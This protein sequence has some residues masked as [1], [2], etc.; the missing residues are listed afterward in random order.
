[1]TLASILP[2][3]AALYSLTHPNANNYFRNF[4]CLSFGIW[5]VVEAGVGAGVGISSNCGS[6]RQKPLIR[7]PSLTSSLWAIMSPAKLATEVRVTLPAAV[8]LPWWLPS[9]KR[10]LT[11]RQARSIPDGAIAT[12]PQVSI[13]V[14]ERREVT[15]KSSTLR[16]RLQAGQPVLTALILTINSLPQWRQ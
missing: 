15:V 7:A 6:I 12:E 11:R 16:R 8:T 5:A 9:T 4:R 13:R 10:L 2:I 3:K 1:L 14:R